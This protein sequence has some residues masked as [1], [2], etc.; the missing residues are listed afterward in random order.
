MCE[1]KGGCGGG[2]FG[3]TKL[4]GLLLK[5]ILCIFF[6]SSASNTGNEGTA[7]GSSLAARTIPCYYLQPPKKAAKSEQVRL[8]DNGGMVSGVVDD[9]AVKLPGSP[10]V[11]Q[12][13]LY[14]GVRHQGIPTSLMC[15]EDVWAVFPA[16]LLF[17]L[18][19]SPLVDVR[20]LP[21]ERVVKVLEPQSL[22]V[23]LVGTCK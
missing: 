3:E 12:V 1:Q 13:I 20:F 16:A 15:L 17:G 7:R 18:P 4:S 5:S 9:F 14:E 22:V 8:R 2:G 6:F 19:V 10:L 23:V 11:V 21:C